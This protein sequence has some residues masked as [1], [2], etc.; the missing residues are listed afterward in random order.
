MCIAQTDKST[1]KSVTVGDPAPT[2]A[3]LQKAL[4]LAISERD[5]MDA[6]IKMLQL[7]RENFLTR[8]INDFQAKIA[9]MK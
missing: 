6:T 4:S 8:K 5:A 7:I 9:E 3:E 2:R 1:G